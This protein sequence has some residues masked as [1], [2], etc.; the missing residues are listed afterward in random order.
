M[1]KKKPKIASKKKNKTAKIMVKKKT[2]IEK[3]ETVVSELAIRL[4]AV[5]TLLNLINDKQK[6]TYPT[7][8][9][10][11]PNPTPKDWPIYYNYCE[12]KY[13]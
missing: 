8:P 6:S 13:S 1:K 4:A 12:K 9:W 3:L 2:R 7:N 5:E 11:Y 10:P